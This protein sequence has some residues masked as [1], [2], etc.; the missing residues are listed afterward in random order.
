VVAQ[1]NFAIFTFQTHCVVD[2]H[3]RAH[4]RMLTHTHT[5]TH[6]HTR[7]HT[8]THTLDTWPLI[9]TS[10]SHS[11]SHALPAALPS[12]VVVSAT[13]L[14]HGGSSKASKAL[15]RA[16]R[17]IRTCRHALLIPSSHHPNNQFFLFVMSQKG[18]AN[19]PFLQNAYSPSESL[20]HVA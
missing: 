10:H 4:A 2:V 14:S 16:L 20:S 15:M 9:H 11:C 8:H 7:T 19:N 17:D 1:F 6:A 5:H 3:M 12:N 13:A 18:A